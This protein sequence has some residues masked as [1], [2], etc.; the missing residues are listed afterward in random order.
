MG[1]LVQVRD[2]PESVHRVLKARAAADGVSLSEFLRVTLERAAATPTIG[3][4]RG[5][6]DALAPIASDEP[7][8]TTVRRIRDALE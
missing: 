7:S 3:E 6:L 5:A 2:V 4:L 8:A 1:I